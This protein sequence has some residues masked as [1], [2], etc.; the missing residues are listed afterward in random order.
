MIYH[1]LGTGEEFFHPSSILSMSS[2]RPPSHR[3]SLYDIF[4]AAS[5]MGPGLLILGPR[6]PPRRGVQV[7]IVFLSILDDDV[8]IMGSLSPVRLKFLTSFN[9]LRTARDKADVL[10]FYW[11]C[12]WHSKPHNN[13][14]CLVIICVVY[15]YI[16]TLFMMC[17]CGYIYIY[18]IICYVYVNPGLSKREHTSVHLLPKR[19]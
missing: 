5:A 11:L 1:S 3:L 15:I 9:R 7:A 6:C 17:V 18:I 14:Q 8:M 4:S 19:P 13:L 2:K 12:T 10:F 16:Y